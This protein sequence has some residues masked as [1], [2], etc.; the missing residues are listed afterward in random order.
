LEGVP[1]EASELSQAIAVIVTSLLNDTQTAPVYGA[2]MRDIR[3]NIPPVLYVSHFASLSL[4]LFSS[5]TKK[6]RPTLTCLPL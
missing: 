4:M 6:G 5:N 1:R 2:Q 3:L